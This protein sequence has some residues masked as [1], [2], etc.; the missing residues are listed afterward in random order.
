MSQ[1][2]KQIG[3]YARERRFLQAHVSVIRVGMGGEMPDENM[4]FSSPGG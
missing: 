3:R 4:G 1:E 2:G